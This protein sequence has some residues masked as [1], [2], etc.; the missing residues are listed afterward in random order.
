MNATAKN[1]LPGWLPFAIGALLVVQFAALGAWQVSRGLEKRAEQELFADESGYASYS[2][3]TTT[4][5]YQRIR[6]TGSPLA[7]RQFLLDNIILESRI[8]HY[9]ILPLEVAAD[10]PLL[11]VNRGWIERRADG[12]DGADLALDAGRITVRG[13]A[14]SL[15][16]AGYKMGDAIEAGQDW[17]Q[18]AVYPAIAD[19]EAALGR[20][21]D[22]VVLLLDPEESHGFLRYWVP[23]EMGPGRHFAYA[24]QWFAMGAV[25][26]ALLVWHYRRQRRGH[27]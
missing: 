20:A 18:H 9:V 6:A 16:R 23:E 5:P 8:G 14:G 10:E 25:L 21:V 4:R 12:I 3:G 19:I 1:A 13:R 24:L 11:L 27:G 17:P 22:P 15:P 26:A 2:P 7:E